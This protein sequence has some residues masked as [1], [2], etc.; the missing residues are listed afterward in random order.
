MRILEIERIGN[1]N[2]QHRRSRHIEHLGNAQV[3]GVFINPLRV[4]HIDQRS[5]RIARV[6]V[7]P[8]PRLA[9]EVETEIPA[10]F[11]HPLFAA[12]IERRSEIA[13][14]LYLGLC[15]EWRRGIVRAI[16]K[17]GCRRR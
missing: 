2:E 14:Q 10:A 4:E 17:H 12:V 5:I 6:V 13:T 16:L 7:K 15:L 9:I 8:L 1:F 3:R 11:E